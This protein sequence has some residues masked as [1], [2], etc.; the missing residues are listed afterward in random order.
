M[1]LLALALNSLALW[2]Q[3]HSDKRW[4]SLYIFSFFL[5]KVSKTISL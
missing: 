4:V 5:L 2:I 1:I 3:V